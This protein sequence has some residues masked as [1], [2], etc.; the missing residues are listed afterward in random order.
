[1]MRAA[2]ATQPITTPATPPLD[3]PL[4]SPSSTSVASA[5]WDATSDADKESDVEL[6][7]PELVKVTLTSGLVEILGSTSVTL[8][9]GMDSVK[10]SAA[11]NVTSV[12]A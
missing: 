7:L 11:T 5:T 8:K 2:A 6:S 3:K 1:M 10:Y 9:Q 12:Q 4:C